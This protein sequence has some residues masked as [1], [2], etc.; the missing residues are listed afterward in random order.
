MV[1]DIR[2]EAS[3]L[4]RQ[5]A[6]I[7]QKQE[8]GVRNLDSRLKTQQLTRIKTPPPSPPLRPKDDG[9]TTLRGRDGVG[10][11]SVVEHVFNQIYS[12]SGFLQE[13]EV[14]PAKGAQLGT[15]FDVYA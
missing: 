10:S 11:V 13:P 5:I 4:L 7:S 6:N 1:N 14:V 2:P 3:A 15:R 12:K 8:S 9:F